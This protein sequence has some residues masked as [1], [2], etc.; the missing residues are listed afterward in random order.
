MFP[1]EMAQKLL[2]TDRNHKRLSFGRDFAAEIQHS[3]PISL[4]VEGDA[5]ADSRR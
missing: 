5:P 2:Y 1:L 4:G 3:R